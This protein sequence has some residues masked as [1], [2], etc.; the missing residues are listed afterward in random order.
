MSILKKFT[1]KKKNIVV[2]FLGKVFTRHSADKV[3]SEN[4]MKIIIYMFRIQGRIKNPVKHLEWSF[5]LIY[6]SLENP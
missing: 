6:L 3:W 5:L 1:K 4:L 2:E